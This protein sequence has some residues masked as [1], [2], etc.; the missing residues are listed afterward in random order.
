MAG[1]RKEPSPEEK[2]ALQE[3]AQELK[4]GPEK[5]QGEGP[6]LVKIRAMDPHDQKLALRLHQIIQEVAPDLVPRLWYGMPA[7]SWKGKVLLFFQDAHKFRSRYATLGFS[8]KAHLDEGSMWP[9]SYALKDL[10]EAEEME[11]RRLI[12]KALGKETS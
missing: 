12:L 6:V 11:I 8:D 10:G 2:A 5:T 4:E 1:Q 9:T 7:Y 3:W